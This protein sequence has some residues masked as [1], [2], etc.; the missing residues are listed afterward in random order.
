MSL[1]NTTEQELALLIFNATAMADIAENDSSSPATEFDVALHTADPGDGGTMATSEAAYTGYARE[2]VA[3]TSGGWSVTV[4]SVGNVSLITFGTSSDG[5][6][7]ITHFS[8][9]KPGGGA[10]QII[11]SGPLAVDLD[12]DS[13]VTPEFPTFALDIIWD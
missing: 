8:V 3:R 5:P 7:V 2:T 11:A 12:V 13:G 9:G 6:E 4:G 10:T 1:G